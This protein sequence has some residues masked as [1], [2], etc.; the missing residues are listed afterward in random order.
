MDQSMSKP[1]TVEMVMCERRRAPVTIANPRD[2]YQ[3]LKRYHTK[4]QEHFVVLTLDGAHQVIAIRVVS[5]GLVNRTIV[6][7]R[8]VFGP[9]IKDNAVAIIVAH[10]HPSGKTDPSP[11]DR[12]ITRRLVSA[13]ELLGIEVLDHLIVSKS[14][15]CSFAERGLMGNT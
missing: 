10:N 7:P 6:H 13:G 2:T 9:A 11:E 8:E 1:G 3:A 14:A 4:K 12:D 5:M 15:Y